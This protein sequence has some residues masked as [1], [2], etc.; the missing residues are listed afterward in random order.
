[1]STDNS[2][3]LTVLSEM[4][5]ALAK[6]DT[7]EEL[8]KLRDGAEALRC[9]VQKAKLGLQMHN[10]AAEFK[11]RAERKAGEMLCGL[12]LYGGDRKSSSHDA[13]LKLK[14]LGISK[15]QSSRWQRQAA[16]SDAQFDAFIRETNEAEKEI[17][18][19]E[20]LRRAVT[21]RDRCPPRRQTVDAHHNGNA[22][23]VAA[24]RQVR[25][26]AATADPSTP[27]AESLQDLLA[28]AEEHRTLL[29]RILQPYCEQGQPI[30]PAARRHALHLLEEL[31]CL[32]QR[33]RRLIR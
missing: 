26:T 7:L 10:E 3:A 8:T 21:G 9:L 24:P 25:P 20:L 33:A 11:L 5:K 14:D 15:D 29:V 32:H 13:N 28:D 23:V 31:G 12:H 18:A 30:K 19:A 17:T 4:R 16:V 2:Q 27:E 1:M 22:Y 6:A